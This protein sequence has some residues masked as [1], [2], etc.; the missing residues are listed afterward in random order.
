M[1][2]VVGMI[3]GI[4][5]DI[6]LKRSQP[7]KTLFSALGIVTA[8]A[9]LFSNLLD[10]TGLE[11]WLGAIVVYLIVRFLL[12]RFFDALTTH[13]GVL[14]SLAAAIMVGF[15]L[16]AV[17]WQQMNAS[18]LQSWLLATFITAGYL[19]H[20]LLDEIYSVDFVG[21]R[22]KRSFGS[23][24]KVLDMQRLPASCLVV[25]VMLVSWFWTAPFSEAWQQLHS[26]YTHWRTAL[27]P[28]WLGM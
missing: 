16:C 8:T 26:N 22:I 27:L 11:L 12:W 5:P 19:I 1:L 28:G 25:F 4:L 20:L 21:V 9:W 24:I 2:M 14:H 13:R 10:Y 18:A 15:L 3:G 17:A 6:D 23:A 7:S